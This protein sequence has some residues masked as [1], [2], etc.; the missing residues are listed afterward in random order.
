[1]KTYETYSE[2]LFVDESRD[3]SCTNSKEMRNVDQLIEWIEGASNKQQKD[4]AKKAEKKARQ[5]LKKLADKDKDDQ[6][7]FI[8]S[9]K[10]YPLH[11]AH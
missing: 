11:N 10:K 8:L 1:M 9:Y 2:R 7:V 4:P 5:K 3:S 6:S